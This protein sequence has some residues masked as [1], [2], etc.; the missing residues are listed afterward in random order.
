[1]ITDT[2]LAYAAG[3]IDSDGFIGIYKQIIPQYGRVTPRYQLRVKVSN[4]SHKIINYFCITFGG[5]K[6]IEKTGYMHWRL[7]DKQAEEFLKNIYPYLTFKKEQ[8]DL[9]FAFRA[10]F[11]K[12]HKPV[13]SAGKGDSIGI[14]V[15]DKVRVNDLVYKA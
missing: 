15:Q 12:Q 8:A 14:K 11:I 7:Y 4:L 10:T 13:K 6:N 1:M 9:A 5:N 2:K 3:V